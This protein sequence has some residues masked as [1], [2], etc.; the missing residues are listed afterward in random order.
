MKDL[1]KKMRVYPHILKGGLGFY[2]QSCPG[3]SGYVTDTFGE[4]ILS[5]K[6]RSR[7][8][9]P[10]SADPGGFNQNSTN[11]NVSGLGNSASADF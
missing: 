3:V 8:S 9:R 2:A 11:M 10:H 1:G 4:T 7:F 5:S 6:N